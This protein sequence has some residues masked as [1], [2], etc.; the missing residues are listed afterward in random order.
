MDA[1][2]VIDDDAQVWLT[3]QH[4]GEQVEPGVGAKPQIQKDHVKVSTIQGFESGSTR[5]DAEHTRAGRFK[6]EPQRLPHTRI[7]V[8]HQRRPRDPTDLGGRRR[9]HAECVVHGNRLRLRKVMAMWAIQTR[10]EY[11]G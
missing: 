11:R 10:P 6:A 9:A 1:Y 2:A 3:R 4:L 7:V 8:H 5:G